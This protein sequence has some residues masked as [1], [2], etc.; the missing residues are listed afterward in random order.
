MK[1]NNL[2]IE[3]YPADKIT[4]LQRFYRSVF[5]SHSFAEGWVFNEVYKG[6]IELQPDKLY[7][8]IIIFN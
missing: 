6:R 3:F 7:G 4:K 5:L 1:E 8:S 2:N